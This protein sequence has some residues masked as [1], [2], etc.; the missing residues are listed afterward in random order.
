MAS[1]AAATGSPA[2]AGGGDGDAATI[3][4][5]T[6]RVVSDDMCVRQAAASAL[7]RM[8]GA[9]AVA[10]LPVNGAPPCALL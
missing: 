8:A 5:L 10:D 2:G 1:A 7:A 6:V 9:A 3:A 4:A